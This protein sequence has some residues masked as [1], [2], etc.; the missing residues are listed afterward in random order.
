MILRTLNYGNYGI[1]LIMCNAGF[2]PS[3]VGPRV[4]LKGS[5][6]VPLRGS[7]KGSTRVICG[8]S[9]SFLFMGN[10]G[11]ISSTEVSGDGSKCWDLLLPRM[12]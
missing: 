10:A 3:A 11:F 12:P 2:C 5:I 8:N 4:P 7:F 9:G 6:G 1:L